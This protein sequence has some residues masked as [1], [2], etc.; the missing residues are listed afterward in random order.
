MDG[1]GQRQ[2]RKLDRPSRLHNREGKEATVRFTID[3]NHRLVIA[4]FGERLTAIDI[5]TYVQDL[6]NHPRFHSSFSEIADISNVKELP[7]EAADFLRLAD[8]VDPFSIESKRAFVAQT[9]LQK[10]AARMH[11]I[12]RSQ[13][14]FEIFET[15]EEAKRWIIS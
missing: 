7:L 5:Q 15:L 9:S 3:A 8:S 2:A 4:G 1:F 6:R 13:R 14:N 12:L 11:K 10:H